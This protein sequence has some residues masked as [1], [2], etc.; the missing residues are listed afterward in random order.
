MRE[1]LERNSE[2]K[3]WKTLT[4][5]GDLELPDSFLSLLEAGGLNLEKQKEYVRPYFLKR[6][7][8]LS[9][10][11][12]EK[13]SRLISANL[14]R[15]EL[16][17]RAKRIGLYCPVR[18]E[19]DTRY[20][21]F[22][23]AESGKEAYFPRVNGPSLTFHRILN[24]NELLPG[25]Y[26]IPEPDSESPSIAPENLDLILVPGV[27]FDRT[28]GRLGYG[29]GYYDRLLTFIPPSRRIGLAYSLQM[30]DCLPRGETDVSVSSVVTE[31]G[32][33]FCGRNE[34]GNQ[35]E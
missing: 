10:T 1:F 26:G 8:C 3:N 22:Q 4:N 2:E 23:S 33:I 19:A 5:T 35:N 30:S 25:K 24:L 21:Y 17:I 6:R 32:V 31:S 9:N 14:G 34:G 18:N 28:G 7:S 20:I 27:A 13:K 16:F 11:D 29:K 15:L 12:I